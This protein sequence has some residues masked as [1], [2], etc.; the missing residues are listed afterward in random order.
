M[1]HKAT[2]ITKPD[3]EW[4]KAARLNYSNNT[5]SEGWTELNRLRG[6]YPNRVFIR[7]RRYNYWNIYQRKPNVY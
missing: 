4:E 1:F 7:I 5:W 6:D 2:V 3:G